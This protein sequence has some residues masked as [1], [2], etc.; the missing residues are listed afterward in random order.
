MVTCGIS[1]KITPCG[2]HTNVVQELSETI[3]GLSLEE[4][5]VSDRYGT[6]EGFSVW[7]ESMQRE[8]PK[9]AKMCSLA[10]GL[11]CTDEK[12]GYSCEGD[13]H[14]P[15]VDH[16]M[17]TA[18]W[19]DNINDTI[20]CKAL[21]AEY[22]QC[23][24]VVP[25]DIPP[26]EESSIEDMRKIKCL[27][28]KIVTCGISSV[29][30]PRSCEYPSDKVVMVAKSIAGFSLE[31][32]KNKSFPTKC[33]AQDALKQ[34]NQWE[35]ESRSA[36]SI[37]LGLHCSASING[38]CNK[39]CHILK[40]GKS[41]YCD[42]VNKIS[43]A[44]DWDED[45][46]CGDS[47]NCT[48]LD[49]DPSDL[50]EMDKLKCLFRKITTCGIKDQTKPCKIR[51]EDADA[52]NILS[53]SVAELTTKQ[54]R[55]SIYKTRKEIQDTINL[56]KTW[57]KSNGEETCSIADGLT[58]SAKDGKCSGE[59]IGNI[60]SEECKFVNKISHIQE[61]L[62]DNSKLCGK[63]A[64]YEKCPVTNSSLEDTK[65]LKCLYKKIVTCGIE[66]SETKCEDFD[67]NIKAMAE[68]IAGKNPEALRNYYQTETNVKEAIG[69]LEEW[70]P[71]TRKMCS[72]SKGMYCVKG[73]C[74]KVVTCS[75]D[76][77][78]TCEALNKISGAGDWKEDY[79]CGDSVECGGGTK[80][81]PGLVSV[82]VVGFVSLK[83]LVF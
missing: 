7:H 34:L 26:E 73:K 25:A 4:L 19:K 27:Y 74:G 53:Q 37:S 46:S 10:L 64:D 68:G 5:A 38:A 56:F 9:V 60:D 13:D 83:L 18:D 1:D 42:E 23:P 33:M 16:I 36:C 57:W 22:A 49:Q 65:K 72:M 11:H 29:D 35:P 2:D 81:Q 58:C 30:D 28:K 67:R 77:A 62:K 51:T 17:R 69:W 32:M 48:P 76:A 55:D 3:T 45:Y 63:S 6:T 61:W 75:G 15:W 39:E 66:D 52:T 47:S 41:S 80:G 14:R 71:K 20:G 50:T 79:D 78:A 31:E 24:V 8:E 82:I 12:C 43:E 54:M 70:D 40:K 59:C 21:G 44:K